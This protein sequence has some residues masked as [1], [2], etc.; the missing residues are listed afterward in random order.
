M[1][2]SISLSI[3]VSFCISISAIIVNF[4]Y[5]SVYEF[6]WPIRNKMKL[7]LSLFSY[8]FL[9]LAFSLEFMFNM[10][11]SH[12]AKPFFDILILPQ[13]IMF[14]KFAFY[15][16]IFYVIT[17]SLSKN[18]T[19]GLLNLIP[20]VILG[21]LV[22]LL[23]P[24]QYF[25]VYFISL[26][27]MLLINICLYTPIIENTM[28]IVI[29]LL[30]QITYGFFYV[31]KISY[32]FNINFQSLSLVY[33]LDMNKDFINIMNSIM[34]SISMAFFLYLTIKS[35]DGEIDNSSNKNITKLNREELK[36]KRVLGW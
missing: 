7:F 35:F 5:T 31:E 13:V 19:A 6:I 28:F 36:R 16:I 18:E 15:S 11:V 20:V 21:A 2:E 25:I 12:T 14:F 17:S 32:I 30:V 23:N 9:I 3:L 33:L 10:Y 26:T 8:I 24:E 27:F 22:F 34:F 1:I 29:F 4:A